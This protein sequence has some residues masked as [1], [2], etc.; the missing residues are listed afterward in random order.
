MLYPL[1]TERL[2]IA[3]LALPDLESF[4]AYRQDPEIARFQSWEPSYSK[5]QAL[6]LIESQV[7]VVLPSKGQWL[8]LAIHHQASAELVGDLALHALEENNSWFE[9]GFTIAKKYQGQGFAKEAAL[10]LM[11]E[12]DFQGATKFIATTDSRNIASIKVLTALGFQQQPLKGWSEEFKNE[13]VTVDY[14]ETT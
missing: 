1:L 4:L 6:E 11:N 14:F 12:L 2:R 5:K 3:P 13:L 9:I 7:G 8:Q 10:R